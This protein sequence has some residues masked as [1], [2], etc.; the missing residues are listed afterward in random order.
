MRLE[1]TS[2]ASGGDTDDAGVIIEEIIVSLESENHAL[3]QQLFRSDAE[4]ARL[5]Q[6]LRCFEVQHNVLPVVTPPPTPTVDISRLDTGLVTHIVSFVGTSFELRNLALT[7]KFFGWQQPATGLDLSLAEEIARKLVCSWLND[8]AGVRITLSPYGRGT[9][10]WISILH[11][12]EHPLKFDTLL[13]RGIE[14]TNKRRTSVHA[15]GG[16]ST[17]VASNFVMVSGIHY[18]EFQFTNGRSFIG[19]ARPMPNLDPDRFANGIFHFF[20]SPWYGDF[21]AA[22]T[23][24]WGNGNVHACHCSL[25]TGGMSWTDWDIDNEEVPWEGMER[26]STGDTIGMLLNL[27]DGTMTVYKNNRRLG[28]MKD[29]LSGPYCWFVTVSRGKAVTIKKDEPPRG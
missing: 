2:G 7:C 19:V 23:D 27:D 12:S 14:H 6:R 3:R 29:G 1:T 5:R 13:G 25:K 10:T 21:L 4:V 8:M 18:T 22:K 28:V 9:A 26:C 20:V 16:V 17:A 15:N 11:E 24:E